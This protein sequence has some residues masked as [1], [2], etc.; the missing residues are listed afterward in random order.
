MDQLE[1]TSDSQVEASQE[2]RK[3]NQDAM[4]LVDSRG[5]YLCIV[6]IYHGN[7]M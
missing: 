3:H 4:Q 6:P 7:D 5:S 2:V 1:A